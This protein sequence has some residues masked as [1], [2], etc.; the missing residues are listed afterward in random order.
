MS[1]A[2]APLVNELVDGLLKQSPSTLQAPSLRT[3][4]QKHL[5]MYLVMEAMGAN[6]VQIR[7]HLGRNEAPSPID[8]ALFTVALHSQTAWHALEVAARFVSES[9]GLKATT[10]AQ[11]LDTLREAFGLPKAKELQEGE[12]AST[13]EATS[14]ASQCSLST[15][16]IGH[17][18]DAI[19]S[20]ATE[21]PATWIPGGS[22]GQQSSPSTTDFSVLDP[23]LA[24]S[25]VEEPT[26]HTPEA[27]ESSAVQVPLTPNSGKSSRSAAS[28][29]RLMRYSHHG[30]EV[31]PLPFGALKEE[32]SPQAQGHVAGLHY[33]HYPMER[34]TGM[35]AKETSSLNSE[36]VSLISH[37]TTEQDANFESHV[38]KV[39]V[40][41]RYAHVTS[42]V[43]ARRTAPPTAL[44]PAKSPQMMQTRLLVRPQSARERSKSSAKK[45]QASSRKSTPIGSGKSNHSSGAAQTQLVP[46]ATGSPVQDGAR[47]T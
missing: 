42:R 11:L 30:V 8:R 25:R 13:A 14:A 20:S 23:A 21:L 29:A 31:P 47:I 19:K 22:I 33:P 7:A 18:L 1:F 39:T 9:Y 38:V 40:P 16:A 24:L 5:L 45:G 34:M 43:F 44:A 6:P 10:E 4:L 32:E 17:L 2:I 37:S 41:K 3:P 27:P 35:A 15:D 12:A 36:K 28:T 26:N 46:E